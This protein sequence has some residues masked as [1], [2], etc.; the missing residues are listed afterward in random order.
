MKIYET[1]IINVK[2]FHA[3]GIVTSSSDAVRAVRGEIE[4]A[5]PQGNEVNKVAVLE[6]VY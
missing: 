5:I 2:K 1:P 3:E 6:W 4:N